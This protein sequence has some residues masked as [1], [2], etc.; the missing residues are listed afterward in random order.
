MWALVSVL[1]HCDVIAFHNIILL[2]V[3]LECTPSLCVGGFSTSGYRAGQVNFI[4]ACRQKGCHAVRSLSSTFGPSGEYG[5]SKTALCAAASCTG[6]WVTLN[7]LPMR[8]S[9]P[10]G[11]YTLYGERLKVTTCLSALSQVF[12][13]VLIIV[14]VVLITGPG[15]NAMFTQAFQREY[16]LPASFTHFLVFTFIVLFRA[17]QRSLPLIGGEQ[18]NPSVIGG[19]Q[20]S[21]SVIGGEQNC[22]FLMG[23]DR[24]LGCD[25]W[26]SC[27]QH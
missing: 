21:L 8:T 23:T 15:L 2:A 18:G 4:P 13:S 25:L 17:A 19:E 7:F 20:K 11:C 12:Y 14:L 26:D 5:L 6:S 3:R 9:A 1:V 24:N 27:P 10:W 22:S 16:S